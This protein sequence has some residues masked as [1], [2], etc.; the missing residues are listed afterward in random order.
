MHEGK[1]QAMVNKGGC[2]PTHLMFADGIFIFCN[3]HK[4]TL[5]N[6]MSL[7]LQYQNSSR[8]MVNRAKNKCFVG[9]LSDI[10][11]NGI[12]E[13]LQ[14]ELSELPDRYYGVIINP[15]IMKAHQVW[16]M[17]EMM[18]KILVGWMWKLL[19]FSTILTLVKFELFSMPMYNMSLY[20]WPKSVIK[21]YENII[22]NF[23]WFGDPTV[24]NLATVKWDEVNAPVSEGGFGI[25]RLE[26][27][28]KIFLMKLF[29]KI[30]TEDVEWTMYMRDEHKNKNEEWIKFH[31]KSSIWPGMKWVMADV[32]DSNRWLVE[33]GKS[34]YYFEVNELSALGGGK[35]KKAWVADLNGNCTVANAAQ[36]VR[37]KHTVVSWANKILICCDGASKGNP[38]RAGFG[39]VTRISDGGCVGAASD[40]FIIA[41]NHLAEVMTL[42]SFVE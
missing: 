6:L 41:T 39:F 5:N 16:G 3:G 22:R 36:L 23:L 29:W 13:F 42:I 26:L 35:D 14:M 24:K 40:G 37:K 32:N 18:Q 15:G 9:G 30:E 21:E 28:N 8:Q 34:I 31:R 11:R 38:C 1:I 12:A 25:R 19:A 33:D 27:M 17:V 4:R 20:K 7:L 10:R 2:K